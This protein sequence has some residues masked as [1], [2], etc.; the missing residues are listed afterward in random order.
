MKR[1]AIVSPIRTPVA[2]FLGALSSMPAGE[3]GAVIIKELVARTKIDPEKIDDVIFAQGYGNGEAPCIARWSLLAA[4]LPITIP[5]YQLDRRCGSGLQAVIDAAMMVQTGAADVVIAGGVESMSQAEYYTT[6]MRGG[7]R[8][9]SVTLHDR[10][11]R[12]RVMSQ[13]ISRFGVISGMIETADNLA[14][15]YQISREEADEYAVM[16]HQRATAAW[17]A[18]KFDDELVPV[19]VPQKRGDPV[20]FAKD[21]G[22]RPDATM[23]SLSKLA[24]IEKGGVVTAGNASQQND[25]AAA[26]LVV[27]EDKLAELGLEPMGWFVGWAAAGCEPSRMGI[28]PVPA[29][30]RLFARTGMSWD[31]IDLVELNEAFAPQVLAVLKGWGWD[32]RDRL[33]VNGSGISLGHPIGATGGRILANLLRELHRRGGRYGLE[34]MCIGGGQGIAAVFERA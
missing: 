2:K 14:R 24:P 31:D 17:A 29:V 7:A 16:S 12:G 21:E 1:A 19:A 5:G 13:P 23:E 4:D 15:D 33:N 27:S 6:D 22:F 10:L 20:M 18:G 28:G 34:T 11:A 25:A 32:E 9:G 8:M 30:E 26:C 3:L